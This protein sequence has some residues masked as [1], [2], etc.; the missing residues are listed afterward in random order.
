MQYSTVYASLI[1]T[2][3]ID[4]PHLYVVFMNS[5]FI[6]V[7]F[8]AKMLCLYDK[9]YQLY[10]IFQFLKNRKFPVSSIIIL[11]DEMS[12]KTQKCKAISLKNDAERI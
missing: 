10:V 9:R 7:K 3:V 12:N 4:I 2:P 5:Q 6:P 1:Y 11:P 8:Y